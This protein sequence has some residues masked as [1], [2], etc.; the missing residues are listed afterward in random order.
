MASNYFEPEFN[1]IQL[2]RQYPQNVLLDDKN[3]SIWY[4][5]KD[6][7]S[8]PTNTLYESSNSRYHQ[9]ENLKQTK[10]NQQ[11]NKNK[12][13]KSQLLTD[14]HSKSD[15]R[16]DLIRSIDLSNDSSDIDKRNS[17]SVTESIVKPN[18]LSSQMYKP[19]KIHN[20]QSSIV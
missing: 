19:Q 5:S 15:S 6:E 14:Q 12:I 11:M 7:D 2:H 13:T 1:S 4:L 16:L 18:E 20:Y 3:R 10:E 17:L 9:Q 8:L